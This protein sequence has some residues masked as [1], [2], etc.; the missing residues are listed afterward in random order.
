MNC[1]LNASSASLLLSLW[2]WFHRTARST[3]RG[4]CAAINTLLLSWSPVKMMSETVWLSPPTFRTS[5]GE[6]D[7]C[8]VEFK[9][10]GDKWG[11]SSGAS[12]SLTWST[13]LIRSQEEADSPDKSPL[14]PTLLYSPLLSSPLPQVFFAPFTRARVALDCKGDMKG[15]VDVKS[16]LEA[17]TFK[18]H[19]GSMTP[20]LWAA[21]L[22]PISVV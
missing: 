16:H 1:R 5:H 3:S 22:T 15:R 4:H 14:L 11:R 10:R 17:K 21:W 19:L 12:I 2:I 20:R 9:S 18:L 13:I 8:S 6:A 7:Y